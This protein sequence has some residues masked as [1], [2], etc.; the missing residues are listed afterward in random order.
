[1]ETLHILK[2]MNQKAEKILTSQILMTPSKD[3]QSN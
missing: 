3:F 1:M 2:I